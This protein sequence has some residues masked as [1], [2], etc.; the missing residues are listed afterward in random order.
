MRSLR[1]RLSVFVLVII[2]ALIY[3]CSTFEEPQYTN[4][5]YIVTINQSFN[6]VHNKS[7]KL[8][9]SGEVQ[10]SS[11][12]F[13]TVKLNKVDGNRAI[14]VGESNFDPS[15]FIEVALYNKSKDETKI[16]VRY[17]EDGDSIKSSAFISLV[18]KKTSKS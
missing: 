16:S 10:D 8:I 4:G 13:Y 9:K 7:L 18:Q 6:E 3:G 15:D 2:F 1:L 17:G 12:H 14:V 11:G 5:Y